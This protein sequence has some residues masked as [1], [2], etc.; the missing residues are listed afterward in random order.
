MPQAE[1]N[2]RFADDCGFDD[3]GIKIG[4][5]TGKF[6]EKNQTFTGEGIVWDMPRGSSRAGHNEKKVKVT[7][8]PKGAKWGD[9]SFDV[10]VDKTR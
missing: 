3:C 2:R 7:V 10:Y 5:A 4:Y 6:E 9:R 8:S 1:Q